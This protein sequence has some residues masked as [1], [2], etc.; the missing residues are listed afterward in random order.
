MLLL[1]K[2]IFYNI[3]RATNML[4][5]KDMFSHSIIEVI[6]SKIIHSYKFKM[7]ILI[8]KK[9]KQIRIIHKFLII[10]KITIMEKYLNLSL[11]IIR[12]FITICNLNTT[13]IMNAQHFKEIIAS[14]LSIIK[15]IIYSNNNYKELIIVFKI[16]SIKIMTLFSQNILN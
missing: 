11:K 14:H 6:K 15:I 12:N 13:I 4:H 7:N 1:I 3:Q 10:I 2:I 5:I 16:N 8:L 9:C